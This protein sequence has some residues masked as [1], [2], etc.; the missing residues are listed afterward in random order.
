[1]VRQLSIVS[2]TTLGTIVRVSGSSMII[3]TR[4]FIGAHN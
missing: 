3:G 2:E 1:V 4:P